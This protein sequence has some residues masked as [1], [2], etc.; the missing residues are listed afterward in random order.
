MINLKNQKFN[1]IKL[2]EI[3][4][5]MFPLSFIAGNLILTL[6]LIIFII[7]SLFVIKKEK[8]PLKIG[9]AHW[10]LIAFFFIPFAFYNN[11]ISNARLFK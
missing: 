5:C 11:T 10:L 9:T 2:V 1:Q 4:F 8:L 7:L 3:L 6:N